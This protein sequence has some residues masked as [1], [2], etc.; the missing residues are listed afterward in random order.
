MASATS[1][2]SKDGHDMLR[3]LRPLSKR[4]QTKSPQINQIGTWLPRIAQSEARLL[5]KKIYCCSQQENVQK[6]K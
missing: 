2:S 4:S 3:A 5:A 6:C 1:A